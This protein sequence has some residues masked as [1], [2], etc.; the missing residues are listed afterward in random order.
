MTKA[1]ELLVH[2][3][4]GWWIRVARER[5]GITLAALA[6]AMGYTEGQG[7][8]SL[9]ERGLRPVPSGKFPAIARELGLAPRF[10]VNPPA[11]DEERLDEP[12]DGADDRGATIL[13]D[14]DRRRRRKWWIAVARITAGLGLD[15]ARAAMAA[16]GFRS[17][18][19]NLV[20]L[21]EDPRE[22]TEPN[23]AQLRTLADVYRV[24]VRAFVDLW[25]NP[26]GTD[27]EAL[28][29]LRGSRLEEVPAE[30]ERLP[31]RP[32]RQQRRRAS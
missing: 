29:A 14:A 20:T 26:P 15:Q 25:N 9:W 27:E 19:A 21:W 30:E 32:E 18:K 5:R 28:A 3:R 31:A 13:T 17:E 7:T 22:T 4:R 8:V 11:T 10:L 2:R 12:D 6:E 16:R 24:P 23:E 1:A